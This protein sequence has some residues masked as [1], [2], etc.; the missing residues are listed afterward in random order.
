MH[1]LKVDIMHE[2]PATK[3]DQLLTPELSILTIVM[4]SKRR[5]PKVELLYFC[6]SLIPMPGKAHRDCK[7][8]RRCPYKKLGELELGT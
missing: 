2:L 1:K 6:L 7:G 3:K 8:N 4:R 5:N